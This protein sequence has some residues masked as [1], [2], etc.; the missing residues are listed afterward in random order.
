MT[1]RKSKPAARPQEQ[2]SVELTP[3]QVQIAAQATVQLFQKEGAVQIPTTWAMN[4]TFAVLNGFLQA[5][6]QGI[7]ILANPSM[8][9]EL[10][11][12]A[13]EADKKPQP[14]KTARK[15]TAKKTSAK[16]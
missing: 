13:D 4:G 6:A 1:A 5:L 8:I 12:K 9:E 14:K 7:V 15:K 10:Q 16:K 3:Q 2:G 11:K